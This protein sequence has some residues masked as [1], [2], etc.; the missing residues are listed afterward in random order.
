[1]KVFSN[2]AISLDGRINTVEGRFTQIGSPQDHARMSRLRAQADAVLVGGATYRLWPHPAVPDAA[3]A[4]HALEP[5]PWNVVVSR[6]MALPYKASETDFVT[7]AQTRP[8]FLTHA[9]AV[10]ADLLAEH[11]AYNGPE[12]NLPVT[13][14]LQTLRDRGIKSLLIEAGGDLLF[15]FL[16][17]NAI[18]E[19]NLTLCPLVIGG[20][21]PSLAGGAGFGFADM[22][23]FKLLSCEQEGDELFLSYAKTD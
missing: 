8:L 19:I 11:A 22:R 12:P 17:A 21:A 9:S 14:I 23:R 2:N 18:D 10:P 20:P 1:L 5:R 15:Q 16:A 13:W 3:D 6:S 4:T 7:H